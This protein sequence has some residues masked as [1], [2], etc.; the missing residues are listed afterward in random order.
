MSTFETRPFGHT[1]T[2][3][4]KQCIEIPGICALFLQLRPFDAPVTQ[5]VRSIFQIPPFSTIVADVSSQFSTSQRCKMIVQAAR[6]TGTLLGRQIVLSMHK[7][8]VTIVLYYFFYLSLLACFLLKDTFV[9]L[10]LFKPFLI[11]TRCYF[12]VYPQLTDLTSAGTLPV[13]S[14]LPVTAFNR[15]HIQQL[16]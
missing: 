5:Y 9:E 16:R 13:M 2:S 3:F 14:L 8:M 6:L 4:R 7:K 1:A 11:E 12:Q 15:A 10:L